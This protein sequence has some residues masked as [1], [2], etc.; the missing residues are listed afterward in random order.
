[1]KHLGTQELTTDRLILR[2]LSVDD[3]KSMFENW[4]SS[5]FSGRY[6]N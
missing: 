5:I 3:A 4:A 2:K 1:M 6:I